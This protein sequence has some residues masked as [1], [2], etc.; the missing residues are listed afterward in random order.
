MPL[1]PT[2]ASR[3]PETHVLVYDAGCPFCTATASWLERHA[4]V[5][6]RL[7]A[8]EEV[9]ESGL[10]TRLTQAEIDAAAHLVTPHGI[11]YHG[12]EAVTRAL[13]LARF[14]WLV[15]VLDLPGLRYLRD[16]GYALIAR[17][18]PLL[19]RFVHP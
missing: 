19:S 13:R 11:E 2:R 6:M 5:P 1:K 12:G 7:L 15:S 8:F 14:G 3:P 10:L 16:G 4:R 9:E 17:L 18:R